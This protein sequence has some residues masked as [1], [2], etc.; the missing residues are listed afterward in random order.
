MQNFDFFRKMRYNI[1]MKHDIIIIGGGASGMLCA[2]TLVQNGIE[3]VVLVER[4][5]RLGKKLSATGNGQGNITNQNLSVAHY[6]SD[7]IKKVERI[8]KGFD[9]HALLDFFK[10]LGGMFEADEK[11][12]VY[13]TSRQASSLTDL[14][15]FALERAGV[16]V[17]TGFTAVKISRQADGFSLTSQEGA[18]L[19]GKTVVLATGGKAAK[20][21]GTDGTGYLLAKSLGHTLTPL[22][23]ALVQ[24]KTQTAHIKGLK[25]IRCEGLLRAYDGEKEL[26]HARGDVIFTDYGVSG[27]AV[28]WASSYLTDAKN[29]SVSLEFLPDVSKDELF[30]LLSQKI[31]FCAE[32]QIF[33][34]IVNNQLGRAILKRLHLENGK[35][36][37]EGAVKLL[38]SFTL[39]VTGTLG[40]DYAQVT[41]GG[42]PMSELNECLM[43][44][45]CKNLYLCGEIINVDGECGGYNLQWAFSSGVCV[46]NAIIAERKGGRGHD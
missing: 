45:K 33:G 14:L 43:S 41:K 34:G 26:T 25:G 1:G 18:A 31:K 32:E 38:K 16:R 29:P 19:K 20:N 12:R 9:N 10:N 11:G 4:G 2:L 44:K 30:K 35:F 39:P 27:N 6:F 13:P 24:L 3:D 5:E 40:F 15:R 23:P 8:I 42:V 21:F 17:Q 22:Y 7:D 28:F 36:S 46:A 37:V